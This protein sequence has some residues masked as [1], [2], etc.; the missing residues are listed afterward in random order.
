[1]KLGK[2]NSL[3]ILLKEWADLVEG[4]T[5]KAQAVQDQLAT[6]LKTRNMPEVKVEK[7]QWKMGDK[8]AVRLGM[9]TTKAAGYTSVIFVRDHGQDLYVSW[10]L[11]QR[12]VV[13]WTN[14]VVFA[15]IV[16][17]LVSAV[18]AWRGLLGWVIG[19]ILWLA[20][21]LILGVGAGLLAYKG[22]RRE[23]PIP[24]VSAQTNEILNVVIGIASPIIALIVLTQVLSIPR[25]PGV[26][27]GFVAIYAAIIALG[28][29]GALI[30]GVVTDGNPLAYIFHITTVFDA[31]DSLAMILSV[32]KSLLHALDQVGIDTSQLRLPNETIEGRVG[33]FV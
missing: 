16:A 7:V 19:F 25:F 14:I 32:H 15:G 20:V 5:G 17:P 21:A 29:V 33:E 18:I 27:P 12:Q 26:P 8:E 23:I 3:G 11:Y 6:N 4:Q 28:L 24:N 10:R 2:G 31:D 13:N 9:R 22:L 30:G 1:M